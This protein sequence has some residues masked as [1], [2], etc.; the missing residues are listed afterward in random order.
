MILT[1]KCHCGAT[2]W[3][4]EGDP[5]DATACNCSLCHRLGT[6][7]IYDYENEKVR[8]TGKTPA[9]YARHDSHDPSLEILFCPACCCVL[10]GRSIC[11]AI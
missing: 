8:L 2:G 7:W 11:N 6:L 4:Y 9:S 3:E 1:G 10:S 5:G